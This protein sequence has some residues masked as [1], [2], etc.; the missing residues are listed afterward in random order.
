[1]GELINIIFMLELGVV[2]DVTR[3]FVIKRIEIE[4]KACVLECVCQWSC[5]VLFV[6]AYVTVNGEYWWLV[7]LACN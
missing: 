4:W 2:L 5:T 3:P 6:I 7:L 1:M